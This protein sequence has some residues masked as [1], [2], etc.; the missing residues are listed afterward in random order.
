MQI[1]YDAKRLFN[2]FTGLGNYA[3]TLVETMA[4]FYGDQSYH[5]FTPAFKPSARLDF[6]KNYPSISTHTPQGAASLFPSLWRSYGLKKGLIEARIQIFHGLSGELPIGI[7]KSGVKTVVAIH[8]LIFEKFPRLY[9]FV[10]RNIYRAKTRSSCRRADVVIAISQQTKNDLI[11]WY[12]IPENKIEV[13]YQSC[14][15]IFYHEQW[16]KSGQTETDQIVRTK[17][18]LPSQY[19]LYVGTVN[20]RKNLLGLL[21]ALKNIENA[22]QIPLVVV[23]K[24]AQYL[25][26]VQRWIGENG[27]ENRFI[28]KQNVAFEDLPAIYRRASLF[29]YPSIAEGFGIPII[30]ALNSGTPVLTGDQLCLKEAGGP[31][32]A[33]IDPSN[34]EQIGNEIIEILHD[35]KLRT[36]M[37]STGLEYVENF[38]DQLIA[39]QWFKKYAALIDFSR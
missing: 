6:I 12:Q 31:G 14:H 23:G 36:T 17:Y 38:R 19:L 25:K 20:E 28:L 39:D 4:N 5:L 29:I 35:E 37:R 1:G 34:F 8:D 2:N 22:V 9:P 32:S 26:S 24:G 21:K 18:N 15:P 13:I 3:R 16:N 7:E 30:E 11:D 33:Y 27:M 10:D